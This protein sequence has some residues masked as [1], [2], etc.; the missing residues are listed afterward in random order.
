MP[1]LQDRIQETTTTGGT[2]TL[3]LAGAVTGYRSFNAAFTLGDIT[4]YTIDNGS[5]EWEI[6]VG[7][8]GSGT[9]SRNSVLESSNANALVNFSAGTKRVFCSAPTKVLLPDQT[10]NSGKVLTT[11][12][13]D[14]SWTTTLNGITL[15]NITPGSG[16]F[17][18]LSASSTVSGS[19]F[20]NYLASPP[21]I[22]GTTPAAG[23]FTTLGATGN[24]TLGDGAGDTVT[25]NGGTANGVAYLN[26]S[27]VLTTGTALTF[28]GTNFQK[29]TPTYVS[30][31]F[32]NARDALSG[33]TYNTYDFVEGS[34]TTAYLRN[35]GSVMG[36]SL[37]NEL[38]LFNTQSAAVVFGTGGTER[39]RANQ[40]GLGIGYT[41]LA[42][43]GSN[44]LAVA[45][46]VGIGTSSPDANVRLDIRGVGP[47]VQLKQN[48]TGAA[49]Y[50]V[51]DNTVESGGKRWRFGYTGATGVSLFSLYNQ[52]DNVLAWAADS[53]GN[54]G[55]GVTPSAWLSAFKALE[56]S[57]GSLAAISTNELDLGQNNFY[58][59]SLGTWAYKTTSGATQYRQTGSEH[60]WYT[61]PSG[62]AGNPITFNQ[63]MT[64]TAAGNLDL[65]V[66]NGAVSGTKMR[67]NTANAN[68]DALLI[69]NW[70]GVA[71]T[72]RTAISFD[73]SGFGGFRIGMPGGEN[74][75]YIYDV[76]AGTERARITSAGDLLVGGTSTGY[77]GK[78]QCQT[79]YIRS[80][81]GQ[82][83]Q[84]LGYVASDGV[85]N[86]W[87][88]GREGVSNGYFYVVRQTG[89][90]MYM[91]T[92]AWVATSDSR[93]KKNV[94]NL[95]SSLDKVIA[96]R[97]VRF[98][99]I[100][101]DTQDVGFIAQ[102]VLP[103]IPEAVDVQEDPE[104]M[105]GISKERMI[106]FLVKAI[107]ELH[108]EIET[109]KQRTN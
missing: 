24:V 47:V 46:N 70:T 15:G 67:I 54:L 90:G 80:L 96:L 62:T 100:S 58:S 43:L 49:T 14:P 1:V 57:S 81:N 91:N 35:Y 12:G 50:Y 11:N 98:D 66:G 88:F 93:A 32:I 56:L 87:H 92:N 82:S 68:V 107:Q 4:Y 101:D 84:N 2:G 28:D 63:A 8:V 9:L 53:S 26:G 72:N 20:S 40:Y 16:A 108:A 34:T 79:S 55:L 86:E 99:W 69:S 64:L 74:A 89:V 95:E 78:I 75:F 85:G 61:A 45:G 31:G 106:P 17:T 37:D 30:G 52:T 60:R 29:T 33:G 5:G 18:T 65:G 104:A 10:S 23:N 97:P 73:N 51:I 13:T 76:A 42:G 102:E 59:S 22:G 27:K 3:T 71:T 77:G 36:S 6:G 25:L 19:G 21:A 44:G 48:A 39:F 105:M 38:H 41:S 7:T 83:T 103:L 94:Q 109:L